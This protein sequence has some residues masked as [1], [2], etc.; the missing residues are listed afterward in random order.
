MQATDAPKEIEL[1][2]M[3]DPAQA[4]SLE[5]KQ[6]TC[7]NAAIDSDQGSVSTGSERIGEKPVR[8]NDCPQL[9]NC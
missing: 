7:E 9:N 6:K 5:L 3:E 2:K 8:A 1:D 4:H